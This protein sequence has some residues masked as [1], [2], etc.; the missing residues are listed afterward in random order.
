MGTQDLT[1]MG[2][3]RGNLARQH[4]HVFSLGVYFT[5]MCPETLLEVEFGINGKTGLREL[6]GQTVAWLLPAAFSKV[7]GD[8]CEQKRSKGVWTPSCLPRNGKKLS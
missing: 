3:T 7:D 8:N 4:P 6:S 1:G 2:T 5:L